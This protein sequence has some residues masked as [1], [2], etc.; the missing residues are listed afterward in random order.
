MPFVVPNKYNRENYGLRGVLDGNIQAI[1]VDQFSPLF[2]RLFITL[3]KDIH[4]V[5]FFDS[6]H[7]CCPRDPFSLPSCLIDHHASTNNQ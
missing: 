1:I 2:Q 4:G 7:F 3:P 5:R 6:V